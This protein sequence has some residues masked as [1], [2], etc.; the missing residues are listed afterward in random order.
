MPSQQ[1]QGTHRPLLGGKEEE[2]G[3]TQVGACQTKAE[4]R[5]ET[6]EEVAR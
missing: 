5:R 1:C 6:V 2:S 4:T 3:P